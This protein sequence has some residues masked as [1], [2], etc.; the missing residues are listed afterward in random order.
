VRFASDKQT[1]GGLAARGFL[2][3]ILSQTAKSSIPKE[4]YGRPDTPVIPA[5][6]EAEIRRISG[7]SQPGQKLS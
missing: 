4:G 7:Q 3:V 2:L 5:T 1:Q 6:Q